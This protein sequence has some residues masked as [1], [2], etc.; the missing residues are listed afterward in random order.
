VDTNNN[1]SFDN[2]NL[3]E[4]EFSETKQETPS[5]IAPDLPH[6]NS[7][8]AFGVW[9][10]SIFSLVLLVNAAVIVYALANEMNVAQISEAVQKQS[11]P[12]ILLLSILTTLPAHLLTIGIVWLVVTRAG[13]YPFW[14]TLGWNWGKNLGFWG[15]VGIAL[16]FF[17]LAGAI[18]SLFGETENDLMRILRSSRTAVYAT[19]FLATFTAPLVEETV[20]RGVMYSAFRRS[21]GNAGAIALVTVLFAI[22]HVPQYY[23]SYGVILAILLLSLVLTYVR[24]ATGNLLP[25]VVIHTV[26]NGIQSI[27][28]IAEPFI[29][30]KTNAPVVDP[31]IFISPFLFK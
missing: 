22:V 9:I 5:F 8:V 21:L 4:Q 13:K 14:Q 1:Q 2:E 12:N 15:S 30:P 26:F 24:A 18:I 28:L 6:W 3:P 11:D 20:Y 31:S 16:G 29:F 23:P 27:L 17:L 19:A 25:C 10:F 7:A